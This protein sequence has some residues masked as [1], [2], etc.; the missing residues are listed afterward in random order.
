[1]RR[2]LT[3]FLLFGALLGLFAQQAAYAAGPH[4]IQVS[5]QM[6]EMPGCAM[7]MQGQEKGKMHR[8]MSLDCIASMGCTIPLIEAAGPVAEIRIRAVAPAPTALATRTL[9][10]RGIRP[11]LKPPTA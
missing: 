3:L 10:S 11:F 6:A 9:T 8:D 5:T 1:V 2:F 7:D 4:L